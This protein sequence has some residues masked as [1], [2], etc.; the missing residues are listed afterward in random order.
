MKVPLRIAFAASHRFRCVT[1]HQKKKTKT[2]RI[3]LSDDFVD[4]TLKARKAKAKI[5]KWNHI[6]YKNFCIAKVTIIKMKRDLLGEDIC[7]SFI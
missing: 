6:K 2:T 5:N 3:S 7:K 1:D 4:L